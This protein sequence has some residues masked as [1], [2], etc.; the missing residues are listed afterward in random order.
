LAKGTFLIPLYNY[1]D[2]ILHKIHEIIVLRRKCVFV[3]Q[4]PSF[5]V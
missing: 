3:L 2:I 5:S 1:G 4:E